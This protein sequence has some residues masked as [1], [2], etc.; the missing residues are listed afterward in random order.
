MSEGSK[1]RTNSELEWFEKA[2]TYCSY[3]ERTTVEVRKK[4]QEEWLLPQ[5]IQEN[6]I[7]RLFEAGILNDLRFSDSF[8]RGHLRKGWGLLK[9]RRALEAKQID[10]MKLDEAIG[11]VDMT[12]YKNTLRISISEKGKVTY[13]DWETD[14]KS[15]RL[16]SSH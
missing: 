7:S 14:R 2:L 16:N 8:I 13:R 6:I 3:Q 10:K 4:M 11:L 1:L 12:E 9:I 15:T 5:H